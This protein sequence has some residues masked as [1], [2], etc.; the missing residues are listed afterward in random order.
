MIDAV[1]TSISKAEATNLSH[2]PAVLAVVPDAV[3]HGPS[4]EVN[5]LPAGFG[6][7][8]GGGVPSP[9]P[10]GGARPNASSALGTAPLV[11]GDKTCPAAG[12]PAMIVPEALSLI[13]AYSQDPSVPSAQGLGYTGAGVKIAVFPDGLQRDRLGTH[14]DAARRHRR[15]Q[16]GRGQGDADQLRGKSRLGLPGVPLDDIE[17]DRAGD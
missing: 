15:V 7:G 17:F 14:R 9:V 12:A 4:S 5:A 3:V 16:Q 11:A 13:H 6:S 10:N 8:S 2:D 1:A